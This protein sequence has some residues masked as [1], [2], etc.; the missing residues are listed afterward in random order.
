MNTETHTA[1]GSPGWLE[2]FAK[3]E[4]ALAISCVENSVVR[5]VLAEEATGLRAAA[6]EID[7]LRARDKEQE[8]ILVETSGR[9]LALHARIAELELKLTALGS[10][11]VADWN[12]AAVG[13]VDATVPPEKQRTYADQLRVLFAGP[14]RIAELE[15]DKA[16][17]DHGGIILTTS[18]GRCH[19]VGH[20]LRAAIDTAMK[21][22]K[23]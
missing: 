1:P 21:E 2:D 9:N 6:E 22:G 17:L 4:S 13:A 18:E 12:D 20:D 16:R 3:R 7:R 14:K 8:E 19:F 11:A 10:L 15:R 23:S 5:G